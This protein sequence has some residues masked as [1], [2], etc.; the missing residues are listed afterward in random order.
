QSKRQAVLL[1][2]LFLR[3]GLVRRDAQDY[4]AAIL[5]L[6]VGVAELTGFNGAARGIRPRIEIENNVLATKVLQRNLFTILIRQSELGGFIIDINVKRIH[7]HVSCQL[8][9]ISHGLVGSHPG[10]LVVNS[11]SYSAWS[12]R[13]SSSRAPRTARPGTTRIGCERQGPPYP[14]RNYGRGQVLRCQRL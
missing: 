1:L 6:P 10:W 12:P 2:E 5:N 11:I 8:Y 13:P 14:G 3:L 9:V 4:R 7:G